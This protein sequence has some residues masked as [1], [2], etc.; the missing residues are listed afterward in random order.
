M[1]FCIIFVVKRCP[2]FK[3]NQSNS[4]TYSTI[5]N[6]KHLSWVVWEQKFCILLHTVLYASNYWMHNDSTVLLR[7]CTKVR[8]YYGLSR[9]QRWNCGTIEKYIFLA[10]GK[11]CFPWCHLL[12][13]W[14]F[15]IHALLLNKSPKITMHVWYN[16]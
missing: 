2:I 15:T 13:H 4:K 1:K 9:Q 3:V 14:N 5:L 11:F 16:N 12:K 8:S 6:R 7:H 10:L